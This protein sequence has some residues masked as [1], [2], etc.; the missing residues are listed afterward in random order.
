MDVTLAKALAPPSDYQYTIESIWWADEAELL[1]LFLSVVVYF[2]RTPN[3]V[4]FWAARGFKGA[5]RVHSVHGPHIHRAFGSA[6]PRSPD[7]IGFCLLTLC[8][9]RYVQPLVPP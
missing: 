5:P 2:P 4:A 6:I 8:R 1:V 7:V 3:P 9:V